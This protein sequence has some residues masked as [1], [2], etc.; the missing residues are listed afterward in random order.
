MEAN[1]RFIVVDDSMT[2]AIRDLTELSSRKGEGGGDVSLVQKLIPFAL[3]GV[4]LWAA[5]WPVD[6]GNSGPATCQ[7]AV[8]RY[9]LVLMDATV[10]PANAKALS[11]S[12]QVLSTVLSMNPRCHGAHVQLPLNQTNTKPTAVIS[13]RRKLE[14]ALVTAR[15][16][17]SRDVILHFASPPDSTASDKRGGIQS[18]FAVTQD[19]KLCAWNFPQVITPIPLVRVA[20]MLGYDE[21]SKPS[22]SARAE[23]SLY[24][25]SMYFFTV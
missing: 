23:Q 24:V 15:M 19:A 8:V 18:C 11:T 6:G 13:H 17:T 21:N 1:S 3:F 5:G 10:F 25:S 12:V 4:L 2:T 14:D 16:D 20:D 7:V 9:V 22:P